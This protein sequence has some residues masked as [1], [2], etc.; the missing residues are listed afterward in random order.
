M[1]TVG[2]LVVGLALFVIAAIVAIKIL[3]PHSHIF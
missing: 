1:K 3:L 2:K